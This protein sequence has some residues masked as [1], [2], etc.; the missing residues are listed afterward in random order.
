MLFLIGITDAKMVWY[1]YDSRLFL[2]KL[3]QFPGA[4]KEIQRNLI[5]AINREHFELPR[6]EEIA[7][8]FAD[9]KVFSELDAST[10]FWQIRL[11][12]QLHDTRFIL[13][14][15][16]SW[17]GL[18]WGGGVECSYTKLRQSSV[19]PLRF[20]QLSYCILSRKNQWRKHS[21]IIKVFFSCCCNINKAFLL[22]LSFPL[23]LAFL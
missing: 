2:M 6:R 23:L 8:K 4:K 16:V 10:C 18:G 9:A 11:R 17:I 13:H 15:I 19:T 14:R 22:S 5:N 20:P 7:V 1:L 3:K 12:P 21:Y